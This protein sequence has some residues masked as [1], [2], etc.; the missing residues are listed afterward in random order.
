MLPFELMTTVY[1]MMSPPRD[2]AAW[3]CSDMRRAAVE[4]GT[5]SCRGM[6]AALPTWMRT[7]RGLKVV[8][9]P[10]LP[11]DI[12]LL[13]ELA[14]RPPTP[15]R[16]PFD[17]TG[18]DAGGER[19][20]EPGPGDGGLGFA[21]RPVHR[22]RAAV[23]S[24]LSHEPPHPARRG[25]ARDGGQHADGAPAAGPGLRD[26]LHRLFGP[27]LRAHRAHEPPRAHDAPV[28]HRRYPLDPSRPALP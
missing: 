14:V 16:P 26:R 3:A 24:H 21:Q 15:R 7:L 22:H 28:V 17:S 12:P 10:L 18:Y 19:G 5:Y 6:F 20:G 11:V 1:G 23:I 4:N 13:V 27:R 8:H 25:V 2:G 9:H